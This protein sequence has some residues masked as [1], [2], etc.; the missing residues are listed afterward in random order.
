MNLFKTL[1]LS[2]ALVLTIGA[3][4]C[5]PKDESTQ[6]GTVEQKTPE[7]SATTTS[8]VDQVGS[9]LTATSETEIKTDDGTEKSKLEAVVGTVT[10]Y[11]PGK[12]IKV[13]TGDGDDHSFDLNDNDTTV[14]IEGNVRVGS[15]VTVTEST[16]DDGKKKVTIRLEA[17]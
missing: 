12:K 11:N 13:Q 6:E 7:G 1:C 2:L 3:T 9:T 10:E 17:A 8:E 4:A 14:E 16:A 15:K 5:K